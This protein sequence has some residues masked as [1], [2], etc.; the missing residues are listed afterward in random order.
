MAVAS[1]AWSFMQALSRDVMQVIDPFEVVFFRQFLGLC[2]LVPWCLRQGKEPL[3]TERFGL[4]ATQASIYVLGVFSLFYGLKV[5]PLAQVS[6]LRFSVPIFTAV[7]ATFFLGE[8][9]TVQRWVIIIIGFSGVFVTF[10]PKLRDT[11][12]IDAGSL[13]VVASSLSTAIALILVKMLNRTETPI[14]IT[15]YF[16]VVTAA[17]SVLP[18]IFYWTWPTWNVL[19]ILVIIA[20]L[21]LI[22]QYTTVLALRKSQTHVVMPIDFTKLVW[23]ALLGYIWF[24]EIPSVAVWAGGTIIFCANFYSAWQEYLIRK[25]RV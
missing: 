15:F 20:V 3:R 10:I 21:G 19:G 22:G 2:I 8:R 24:S 13:F 4:H 12:T 9:A 1:A 14:A 11:G 17:I 18:A 25:S 23:A 7:L 6:A 5:V 16:T